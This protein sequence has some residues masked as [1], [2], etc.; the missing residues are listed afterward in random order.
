[1]KASCRDTANEHLIGGGG[2]NGGI[3]KGLL[4]RGDGRFHGSRWP[5]ATV[6]PDH[7]GRRRLDAAIVFLTP[8]FE[9]CPSHASVE[10]E[11]ER[12]TMLDFHLGKI[13]AAWQQLRKEA[14]PV[15]RELNVFEA[16]LRAL[17]TR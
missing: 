1:M 12:V 9:G 15:F 8:L 7:G 16:E 5:G 3:F 14:L 11:V 13:P 17:P 4:H 10:A 2:N 6:R